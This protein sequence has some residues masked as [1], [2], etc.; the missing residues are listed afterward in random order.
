MRV[1]E[2]NYWANVTEGEYVMLL[3]ACSGLGEQ[4]GKLVGVSHVLFS[5]SPAFLLMQWH[6]QTG[7]T[8]GSFSSPER[9]SLAKC[10][11]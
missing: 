5:L 8:K 3:R 11:Q 7:T 9:G 6:T 10:R 4:W 2:H 1:R